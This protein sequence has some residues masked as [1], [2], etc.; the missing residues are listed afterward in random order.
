M[1]NWTQTLLSQYANSPTM[2]GLIERL[3]DAIDPRADLQ[4]LYDW[5][6]NLD[7]AQGF[8]LDIWGRILVLPRNL[9]VL[10][11][12]Y[13]LDD[14]TYRAMLYIK[15]LSNITATNAPSL[16]R[17]LTQ[18]YK[19][20]GR[21]YTIDIGNMHMMFVFEFALSD[22]DLAI[23]QHTSILPHPAGVKIHILQ[24][25]GDQKYFSFDFDNAWLGGFDDSNWS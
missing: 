23:L 7:T 12:T 9:T 6:W 21:A 5:I 1:Q 14:T 8:G 11:T 19:D 2:C 25:T 3:N 4:N 13:T 24:H 22:L 17:L 18:L 20:Q 10:G 15:A 16:N